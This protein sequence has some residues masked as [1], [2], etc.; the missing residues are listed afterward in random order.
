MLNLIYRILISTTYD[1]P[2]FD[3]DVVI[4]LLPHCLHP[5][6]LHYS[7]P[8]AMNVMPHVIM[9]EVNDIKYSLPITNIIRI[10]C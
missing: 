7:I 10:Q 8:V 1:S 5:L 6:I 4:W 9:L 3:T 2:V